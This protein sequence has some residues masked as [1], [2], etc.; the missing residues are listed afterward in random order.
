MKDRIETLLA[1]ERHGAGQ[2]EDGADLDDL[3][4]GQ[5]RRRGDAQHQGDRIARNHSN[6]RKQGDHRHRRYQK[7]QKDTLEHI[8]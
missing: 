5:G 1:C 7:R 3:F 8:T 6:H 4:L 2:G